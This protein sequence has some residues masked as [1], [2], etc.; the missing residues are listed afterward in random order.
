MDGNNNNNRT[1]FLPAIY[2][3]F[4]SRHF[5]TTFLLSL[6]V[7]SFSSAMGILILKQIPIIY[8]ARECPLRRRLVGRVADVMIFL[9]CVQVQSS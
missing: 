1:T 8:G 3:H 2:V 7:H 4:S 5:R 6:F 9:V